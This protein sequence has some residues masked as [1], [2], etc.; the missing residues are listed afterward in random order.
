MV[1]TKILLDNNPVEDRGLAEIS[2]SYHSAA[3]ERSVCIIHLYM[4]QMPALAISFGF[5]PTSSLLVSF[6][7][8]SSADHS[9]LFLHCFLAYPGN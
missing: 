4:H 3:N 8:A 7:I 9:S 1:Q 5:P 2:L 6:L